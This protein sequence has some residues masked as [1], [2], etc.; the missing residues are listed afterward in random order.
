LLLLDLFCFGDQTVVAA[1]KESVCQKH[2]EPLKLFCRDHEA[3]ICVV[4][5]QSQEHRYHDIVPVEEASQEYKDQFCTCMEI[6]RKERNRI[7][8][9]KDSLVKESQ[10]LLDVFEF[11]E[12]KPHSKK[13]VVQR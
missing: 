9:Y 10:D 11:S 3:P 13:K 12:V 4:C 7:L 6:L 5:E 8:A 1:R 2:Q